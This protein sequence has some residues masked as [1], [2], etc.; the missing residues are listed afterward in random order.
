MALGTEEIEEIAADFGS[1][2]HGIGGWRT[3]TGSGP[4]PP[5]CGRRLERSTRES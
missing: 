3:D 2:F 4:F 1:G 5:K